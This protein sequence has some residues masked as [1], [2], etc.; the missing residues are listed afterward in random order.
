MLVVFLVVQ[1]EGGVSHELTW[2]MDTKQR[3]R[4]NM[5]PDQGKYG[6]V[7]IAGKLLTSYGGGRV[8]PRR[9]LVINGV[10]RKGWTRSYLEV[11]II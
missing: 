1:R 8:P 6:K 10:N 2:H 4:H 5:T 3:S 11:L 9:S 7:R